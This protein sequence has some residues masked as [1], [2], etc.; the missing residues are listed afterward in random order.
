[1][2]I[3]QCTFLP[4]FCLF[5]LCLVCI[6][7]PVWNEDNISF[8]KVPGKAYYSQVSLWYEYETQSNSEMNAMNNILPNV[9]PWCKMKEVAVGTGAASEQTWGKHL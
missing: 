8:L 9:Q 4:I 5:F 7:V 3:R 2:C 6:Q 1:M